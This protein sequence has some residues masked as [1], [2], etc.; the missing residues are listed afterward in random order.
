MI[1]YNINNGTIMLMMVLSINGMS[2]YSGII[3]EH[4]YWFIIVYKDLSG[5]LS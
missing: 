2:Y 3:V 5:N 1:W 4:E